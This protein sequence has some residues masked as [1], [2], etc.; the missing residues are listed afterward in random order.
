VAALVELP[1]YKLQGK[2][3]YVRIE[4]SP[5]IKQQH[6]IECD[7]AAAAAAAAAGAMDSCGREYSWHEK[8]AGGTSKTPAHHALAACHNQMVTSAQSASLAAKAPI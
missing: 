3:C 4:S 6:K 5:C 7:T 1:V 8:I 2:S